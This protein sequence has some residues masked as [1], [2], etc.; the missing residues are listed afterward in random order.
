[1]P[2][3]HM[4]RHKVSGNYSNGGSTPYFTSRGKMWSNA[5]A[6]NSHLALFDRE[7]LKKVYKDC[8]IISYELKAQDTMDMADMLKRM[9]QKEKLY[10]LHKDTSFASFI[11]GLEKKNQLETYRWVVYLPNIYG[12]FTARREKNAECLETI[13][14]FKIKKADYRYSEVTFAFAKKEDAAKFRLSISG[15]SVT[16]DATTFA[17]AED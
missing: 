11:D 12:R 10:E 7:R 17:V 15:D 14:N 3:V 4:I 5:G 8:E 16:Y 13:R 2:T 9:E 6:L 1:M